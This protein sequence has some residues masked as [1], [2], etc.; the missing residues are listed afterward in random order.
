MRRRTMQELKNHVCIKANNKRIL[1]V[2][3]TCDTATS[4][5]VTV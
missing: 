1:K 2:R 5:Y 4:K 3:K